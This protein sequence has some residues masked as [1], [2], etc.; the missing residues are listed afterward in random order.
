MR[1]SALT[2]NPTINPFINLNKLG[3][4]ILLFGTAEPTSRNLFGILLRLS[5]VMIVTTRTFHSTGTKL[6]NTMIWSRGSE[7]MKEYSGKL[8]FVKG[9][10]RS[11]LNR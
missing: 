1:M 4:N 9:W 8:Y 11:D 10:A 5:C 7:H 3:F 2:I 6:N